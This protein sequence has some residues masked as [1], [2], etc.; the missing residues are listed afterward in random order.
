MAD[1]AKKIVVHPAARRPVR[2]VAGAPSRVELAYGRLFEAIESGD[3]PPGARL[4]EVE[5]A[6]WLGASRTPVREALGRLEAEGLLARDPGRGLV[7]AELDQGMVAELY[8][9]REVLEG[10]AAGLAAR[11]ASDAEIDALRELA[12]RDEPLG[13]DPVRLA[14]ANR[15]FHDALFRSAHNRFLLRS[16]NALCQSLVLLGRTT[17][18]RA[19]RPATARREH[20]ALVEAIARR[21]EA[22]A[23][24]AAR[25]HIRAAYRTRLAMMLDE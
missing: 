2:P 10:T 20:A 16:V 8:A 25:D 6:G 3:L 5:L 21:D 13:D 14:R 9:M 15:Q 1:P 22:G 11:H 24:Q 4:R 7:V 19:G 18:G 17:L 23:A 12:G